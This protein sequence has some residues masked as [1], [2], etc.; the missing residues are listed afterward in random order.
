M[1]EK[2]DATQG[3]FISDG[4]G[5]NTF[6]WLVGMHICMDVECQHCVVWVAGGGARLCM[7]CRDMCVHA[8]PS[9]LGAL[10]LGAHGLG[11]LGLGAHDPGA[12][13]R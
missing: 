13:S 5:K 10:S 8:G 4:K 7:Q 3:H 1:A 6:S 2:K 12:H 11:A 9:P